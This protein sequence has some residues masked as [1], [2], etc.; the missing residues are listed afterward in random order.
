METIYRYRGR[1]IKDQEL[2]EI[3]EIL[4]NHK[5][6][7]R[8][9]LSKE[10]CRRLDWRQMNGRLQD[11]TCRCLLLRL[12]ESGLVELPP[13]KNRPPYWS[14]KNRRPALVAIDQTPIEVDLSV[15]KPIEIICIQDRMQQKVY[16]SLMEQHHYLRYTRAVGEHIEYLFF[17][18]GKPIG[19]MGWSSAPRH[20]G[21]R[22]RYLGWNQAQRIRNLHKVIVN[23]RFLILPWIRVKNLASYLLGAIA[24]RISADWEKRYQHPIYWL[25]TFVDPSQGFAGTC[26]K[27]ANWIYLGQ[28][29]GRGK[30]DQTNKPNRSLKLVFGYPLYHNVR[31]ALYGV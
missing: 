22:D 15:L 8:W 10:I 27:A 31:E 24:R 5:T 26:Y 28:T 6:S 21:S 20:I 30:N 16:R 13:P 4:D 17:K 25:E 3:R 23:T 7:S 19:G 11:M 18:D 1:D 29:T 2:K 12:E 9:F 14:L